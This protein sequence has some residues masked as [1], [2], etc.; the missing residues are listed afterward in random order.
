MTVETS[1]ILAALSLEEKVELLSGRDVWRTAAIERLG[2]GSIK[3]TDGPVGARGDS[4]T[5]ARAVCLPATSGLAATFDRD[6]AV[7]FGRLLGR[8]TRRKGAQVLLAPTVNLARHPLGGRNFESFG[9]DPFLTAQ[10]AVAYV[11]GVQGEGVAAC[12]KH[13]VANDVEYR[14]MTVSSEVDDTV[15]REL[16]LAPFEA[17][18]EAGIRSL[19]AAYPKLNGRFC[20]EHP[21]LL[22]TLL[23]DQWGFDGLVMSDWGATHHRSRPVTAGLDLEMPGPAT[24]LGPN[25]LAAVADGEVTE[26]QVEARAAAVLE[27]ARRTGRLGLT[28]A[29]AVADADPERTVDDPTERALARRIATEAMVLVANDGLLPLDQTAITNLAVI[30]PNAD[31]AVEQGGGSAQVPAHYVISP[32]EGLRAALPGAEIVHQVGCLAHRYLPPIPTER[33]LDPDHGADGAGQ[34]LTLERFASG[35]LTGDPIRTSRARSV[36]AVI[37]GDHRGVGSQ[38]WT[39]WLPIEISGRHRFATTAVGRSRVLIDGALIVDNWTDPQPGEAFYQ[40]AS[41][42]VIGEVELE[43]GSV[44]E[45]VVEWS[46]DEHA[47]LAGLRFGHLPPVDEHA[48]LDRA[49]EAAAAADAAVVV[50]GLNREWETEGYDRPLFGLPGR[51]NELIERVSAA[52]PRTLVVVNAGSPV[53]APWFDQVAATLMAWYPGQELGAALAEV[54]LGHT[55][56]GGRLPITWPRALADTPFELPM[57]EPGPPPANPILAYREGLDIGYRSYDRRGVEPLVPFGF[58]L[59]YTTFELGQPTVQAPDPAL[60]TGPDAPVEIEIPVTNT[61]D[62]GGKAVVQAYLGWP[63]GPEGEA[64]PDGHRRPLRQLAGFAAVTAEPGQRVT[65]TVTIAA[66]RFQRWQPTGA[67]EG[68][69]VQA[70]GRYRLHVG[71]SSRHLKHLIEVERE[72]ID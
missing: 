6:L 14:R 44:V 16:Y 10:M 63:E 53:E 19:M 67:G 46:L 5:G 28:E 57:P 38:R 3:V 11:E 50:V 66:R 70:G 2:V 64:P 55:E 59:G 17:L 61:G 21:W 34:P 27:L 40:A 35:E 36:A 71:T 4:T 20:S 54:I 13:F 41:A 29:D 39:G 48:L 65:A 45:V 32:V 51:Q 60:A 9:E 42:E 15:L 1:S 22:T 23:R 24:A 49:V 43:A 52:N 12:G 37:H 8:E 33:W 47:L 68:R 26:D 56:P 58:G 62:R 7:E 30:G 72:Q 31:P 18:V 25:L 69:W